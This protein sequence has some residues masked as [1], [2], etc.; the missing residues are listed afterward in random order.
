MEK[1]MS[2]IASPKQNSK[3]EILISKTEFKNEQNETIY[4]KQFVQIFVHFCKI[5]D[6]KIQKCF[7]PLSDHFIFEHTNNEISAKLKTTNMGQVFTSISNLKLSITEDETKNFLEN[8][9]INDKNII[10]FISKNQKGNISKKQLLNLRNY[11]QSVKEDT[12]RIFK[13]Y[14]VYSL[15]NRVGLHLS[16]N[17]NDETKEVI[18][19]SI[20]DPMLITGYDISKWKR[21]DWGK[22]KFYE[23]KQLFNAIPIFTNEVWNPA[24]NE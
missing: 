3:G 15:V 13:N 14:N 11:F 6:G 9:E 8:Y 21:M 1:L 19:I 18:D 5:E 16:V 24:I 10:K 12:T 23:N 22:K 17:Y 4:S 2:V 7:V 20:S